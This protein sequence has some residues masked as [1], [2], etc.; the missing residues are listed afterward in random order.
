MMSQ[1]WLPKKKKKKKR[2]SFKE[3][4]SK[5][6]GKPKELWKSLNSLGMSNEI[7]ISNFNAIEEDN[8]LTHD[9]RSILKV[10]K[11]SFSNLAEFLL[12]KVSKSP[13]KYNDKYNQ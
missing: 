13:D 1:N 5:T 3:K 9:N 11:N 12:I 8:T 4:L 10:F 7:V 2:I 6:I